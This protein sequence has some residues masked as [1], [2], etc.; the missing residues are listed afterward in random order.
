MKDQSIRFLSK[1]FHENGAFPN[2]EKLPM[3][4][5][6]SP[7]QDAEIEP[8]LFEEL[9]RDKSLVSCLAQRPL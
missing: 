3:I 6:Q 5:F 8:E 1:I 9:F 2:N 7:L 4:I